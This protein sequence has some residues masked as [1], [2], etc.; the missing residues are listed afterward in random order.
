MTQR[1][2]DILKIKE[3]LKTGF[4]DLMNQF[5]VEGD[6]TICITDIEASLYEFKGII[7]RLEQLMSLNNGNDTATKL[8]RNI[9]YDNGM[10]NRLEPEFIDPVW[11]E[12][13]SPIAE[14]FFL[15]HPNLLTDDV[16]DE[17]ATGE[18]D[19]IQRKYGSLT[20]FADLDNVLNEYFGEDIRSHSVIS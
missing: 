9:L 13:I 5:V 2:N 18:V 3:E 8:M 1:V 20:G 15:I 19:E 6:E 17:I 12:K 4:A 7:W 16:L 14:R 11:V 10:V